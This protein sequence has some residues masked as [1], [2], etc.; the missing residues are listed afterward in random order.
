[1]TFE[2]KYDG[3]AGNEDESVLN[4][5]AVASSQATKTADVGTYPINITG[6]SADNYR[7][8]YNSGVLTINKAEQIIIWVQ[9]LSN[10]KTGNQIELKAEASSG[11]PITYIMNSNGAAEIYSAGSKQYLE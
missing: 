7:L 5:K 6:G 4:S 3:F 10:L 8:S 1:M 11:L 2:V 9:N